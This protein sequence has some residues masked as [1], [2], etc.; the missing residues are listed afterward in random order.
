MSWRGACFSPG[1][2]ATLLGAAAL[3]LLACGDAE[4]RTVE[5]AAAPAWTPLTPHERI[6]VAKE[7]RCERLRKVAVPVLRHRISANFQAAAEGIT[8][9]MIIERLVKAIP[10]PEIAKYVR[11]KR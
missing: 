4:V 2:A 6:V 1:I 5:S 11:G 10:E 3:R 8:P 9:E 7:P